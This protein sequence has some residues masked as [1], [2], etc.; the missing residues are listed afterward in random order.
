MEK[1]LFDFMKKSGKKNKSER[2]IDDLMRDYQEIEDL[3]NE[4]GFIRKETETASS[5]KVN[6]QEKVQQEEIQQK[7]IKK[8]TSKSEEQDR[9]ETVKQ[10]EKS[11]QEQIKVRLEKKT[12]KTQD[13]NSQ[14]KE[15]K[16]VKKSEKEEV[17]E[18]I[19]VE[20][21]P[22]ILNSKADRIIFLRDHS[23]QILETSRQIETIK[24]EYQSVTNYLTDIQKIDMATENK[25]LIQ[26]AARR[27]ITLTRERTKYQ[28]SEVR[29]TDVQFR[30]IEQYENNIIP[31][32][33][34]IHENESYNMA[35]KNDLRLLE[36]EKKLLKKQR[37]EIKEKQ[38][39]LKNLSIITCS[40]VLALGLLLW[41]ISSA[42]QKDMMIPY[43]MTIVMAAMSAGY[44]FLESQKNHKNMLLVGRKINKAISLLNKVK[45]KFVNNTNA[46]DYEYE[47][48]NVKSA[49]Q[50]QYL[51]DQYLRAKEASKRYQLN[52][53]MLNR[54]TEILMEQLKLIGVR[55]Y[56]I[57]VGQAI[58][59][60][61]PKEMVEIRHR[62]NVRRQK[63]RERIDYNVKMKKIAMNEIKS[64]LKRKPEFKEEIMEVLRKCG[65]TQLEK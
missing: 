16:L 59:I 36:Q 21:N 52:T 14:K 3:L 55:D 31:A 19:E 26:D 34:Q 50:L 25:A 42:F 43:L 10:P 53:E 11:N 1:R 18:D 32:I 61:D 6:Q 22:M 40:L 60:L 24:K 37:Q 17:I 47:K 62:Y 28:Q 15:E 39:Y 29:I 44:I 7:N 63:L 8:G 56:E 41:G 35:I 38:R 12:S 23:E 49:D 20:D 58:A 13:S 27:I 45:I 46:L 33:K 57:W 5:H 65:V 2:S 51:W 9:E 48:Y 64:L 54:Y 30:Q 4:K